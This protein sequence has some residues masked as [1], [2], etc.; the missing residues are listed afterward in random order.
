VS[1]V[2]GHA[3][4]YT[5]GLL[6]AG[7]TSFYMWRL[8]F[9]T[10]CGESRAPA[11]VRDHVSEP[12]GWV[13]KPLWVL[14]ILSFA[15]GVIGIPQVYGDWFYVESSHSLSNFLS[16]VFPHGEPHHLDH[17][18]EYAM[19]LKAIGMAALGLVGAWWFYV[20]SPQLPVRASEIFSG[21]YQLL[22]NKYWVDEIYDATVVRPLVRFSDRALFRVVD[23]GLIDGVA[24]NGTA[25]TIWSVAAYGLKYLQSGLAQGYI[26]L[27]IVGTVAILGY[28]LR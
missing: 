27:M 16:T 14:A 15:G 7:I 26:F 9:K 4:I 13:V 3:W 17:A 19:A 6:T 24:V 18:T 20:R 10:F 12:S 1:H 28:L 5:I 22:R 2:P 21:F 8:F 23:A 11:D 25:R